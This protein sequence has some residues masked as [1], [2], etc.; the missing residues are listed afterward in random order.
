MYAVLRPALLTMLVGAVVATGGP[1]EAKTSKRKVTK[2]IKV[3][4]NAVPI[5]NPST[6]SLQLAPKLA[7][8]KPTTMAA[9]AA[10]AKR[11]FRGRRG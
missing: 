4:V 11:T 1:A 2:P 8:L 7:A 5:K 9:V 10:I 6:G 3:F